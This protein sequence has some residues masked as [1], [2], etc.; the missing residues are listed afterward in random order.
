MLYAPVKSPLIFEEKTIEIMGVL[1]DVREVDTRGFPFEQEGARITTAITKM[2]E[3]LFI[4]TL[5]RT[6]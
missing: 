2:T 1:V 4:S 6:L 3:S 5:L